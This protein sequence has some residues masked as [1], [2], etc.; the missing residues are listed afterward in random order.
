MHKVK[1]FKEVLRAA[2]RAR[3]TG[4]KIVATNGCFDILHVGHVR[5]LSAAKKLGDVLV[6]GIN[7]DASVRRNKGP[8]RPII[9]EKER[10]EMLAALEPVDYVFIFSAETPIRWIRELKPHIHVK[11]GSKDVL[12]HP[13]F[14]MLRKTVEAGGGKFLLLPHNGGKSTSAIVAKIQKLG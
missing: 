2:N 13:L 12:A 8:S 9:P 10:A 11:G 5:N 3:R 14:P 7:S 1:T 4:K 6:V